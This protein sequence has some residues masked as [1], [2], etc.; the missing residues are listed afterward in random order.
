MD[1]GLEHAEAGGQNGE[2]RGQ[3]FEGGAF[4]PPGAG[5]SPESWARPILAERI[6]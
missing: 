2:T 5:R 1:F 3:L 6:G 4:D